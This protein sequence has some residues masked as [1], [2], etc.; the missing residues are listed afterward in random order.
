MSSLPITKPRSQLVIKRML[1]L[2]KKYTEQYESQSAVITTN[3]K[4]G[5]AISML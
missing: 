3:R 4:I 5:L 1:R 2:V